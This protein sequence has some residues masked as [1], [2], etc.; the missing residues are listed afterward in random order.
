MSETPFHLHQRTAL[1][2]GGG[3]GLGYAISKVF[4][5]LGAK[6][7]ITGR[8]EAK[9]KQAQIELGK[10]CHYLVNDI[11]DLDSLPDL[12]NLTEQKFGNIHTLVNNAGIHLKKE[13]LDVTDQEYEKVILTNQKAVFSLTR[14]VAKKMKARKEGSIIMIS[15]M[16]SQYGLPLVIAYSAAKSAIEGMT[17]AL[18]VELSPSNIRINCIAPGFIETPMSAKAFEADPKR[19]E[20]VLGRTPM[21][22]LGIPDDVGYAAAFLASDASQFITGVVLP[23]D[24]GNAIGF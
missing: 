20:K 6:V 17:R 13:A 1:I 15:S 16:A 19:K 8:T 23:V 22:R 14:E 24:G 11:S 12:V 5:S 18:A 10:N 7:I 21:A 4:I 9:L 3:S 2:T